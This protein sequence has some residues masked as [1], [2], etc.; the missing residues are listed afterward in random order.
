[1]SGGAPILFNFHSGYPFS[2]DHELPVG[3][4]VCQQCGEPSR[5]SF[6]QYTSRR[7]GLLALFTTSSFIFTISMSLS[8]LP[9]LQPPSPPR[10]SR[11]SPFN[12]HFLPLS[13]TSSIPSTST[14]FTPSPSQEW[15]QLHHTTPDSPRSA[16]TVSVYS[17]PM[18]AP[19]SPT[20]L[21]AWKAVPPTPPAFYPLSPPSNPPVRRRTH[22]RPAS[23]ILSGTDS[24]STQR[25]LS[26]PAR[27]MR[28][29]VAMS[30]PSAFRTHERRSSLGSAARKLF[31]IESDDAISDSEDTPP[32]LTPRGHS[33]VEDEPIPKRSLSQRQHALLELLISERTY[34]AD[35]RV[36]VNVRA[37]VVTYLPRVNFMPSVG[38][39]RAAPYPCLCKS[40]NTSPAFAVILGNF[41]V[42][43]TR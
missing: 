22:P 21:P 1:M 10:P 24:A 25:R 2:G 26:L 6:S 7:D 40:S 9:P 37:Y 35:L 18:T 12:L 3:S 31:H 16:N 33:S 29:A 20:T 36:L 14:V 32:P 5:V 38:I 43:E 13:S 8:L 11:R 15:S 41:R 23:A 27:V 39:F 19:Q 30:P 42:W 17:T 34:L 4:V 28:T